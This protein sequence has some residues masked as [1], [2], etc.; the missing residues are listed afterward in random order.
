MT[1]L[2][3]ERAASGTLFQPVDIGHATYA[4][5]TDPQTAFWALVDKT[6]LHEANRDPAL[7]AAYGAKAGQFE[8]EL[9]ACLLYTSPS[10][11]D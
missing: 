3:D 7:L 4:A 8:Q 1:V 6:R 2:F 10:P 11:R 9:H 5:V